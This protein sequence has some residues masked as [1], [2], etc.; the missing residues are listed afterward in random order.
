MAP[1][2][3][4]PNDR[5][6][7]NA[8]AARSVPD[9]GWRHHRFSQFRGRRCASLDSELPVKDSKQ[10]SSNAFYTVKTDYPV[11]RQMVKKNTPSWSAI[12]TKLVDFD[13]AGLIGL[14]Q[15]L[16]AASKD[17]K[18]L[19]AACFELSRDSRCQ[20]QARLWHR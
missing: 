19:L 12:K 11:S 5:H 6:Q 16:Y 15:Q 7:R 2:A 13:R 20:P 1:A 9:S 10:A 8:S 4:S 17:N 14:V 18:S 3:V